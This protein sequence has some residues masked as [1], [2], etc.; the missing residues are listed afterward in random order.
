[1]IGNRGVLRM[2]GQ[3]DHC[4]ELRVLN[5]LIHE[6]APRV[7]PSRHLNHNAP[8]APDVSVPPRTDPFRHFRRHSK[9]STPNLDLLALV[10]DSFRYQLLLRVSL[11]RVRLERTYCVRSINSRKVGLVVQELRIRIID[12]LFRRAKIRDFAFPFRVN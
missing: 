11:D 4:R 10:F 12:Y 6:I 8:H 1:M 7:L 9:Q 3:L 2:L 5:V